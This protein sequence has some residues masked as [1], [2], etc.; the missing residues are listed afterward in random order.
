MT[1]DDSDAMLDRLDRREPAASKEEAEAREPYER[2]ISRIR[3][4]PDDAPPDGWEAR[5]EARRHSVLGIK[6]RRRRWLAAGI[7][8]LVAAATLV[9]TLLTYCRVPA[10]QLI[11]RVASSV[12]VA[13][14]QPT[15]RGTGTVGNFVDFEVTNSRSKV[16]VRIYCDDELVGSVSGNAPI[17]GSHKTAKRGIYR[18]LLILVRDVAPPPSKGYV[19][20]KHELEAAGFA[21]TEADEP[22]L[23]S[24]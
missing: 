15:D 17:T 19:D 16:E 22:H 4:L 12:S 1:E 11:P 6:P 23:I 7:G 13:A 21:T 8:A 2:L 10:Q 20:D 9:A 24:L 18:V 14:G 3:D 5:A